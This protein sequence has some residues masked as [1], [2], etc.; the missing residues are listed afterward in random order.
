M[1]FPGLA[2]LLVSG[3]AL[4]QIVIPPSVAPQVSWWLT[5]L[6]PG[7]RARLDAVL[8]A[9]AAVASGVGIAH[10]KWVLER[11]DHATASIA[12]AHTQLK[13]VYESGATP[14]D[15][16]RTE[17]FIGYVPEE[18]E[19]GV[20]VAT[21]ENAE[22]VVRQ[23]LIR[24]WYHPYSPLAPHFESVEE[25]LRR[26][27]V[28]VDPC[29]ATEGELLLSWSWSFALAQAVLNPAYTYMTCPSVDAPPVPMWDYAISRVAN[30]GVERVA[31][32]YVARVPDIVLHRDGDDVYGA[33]GAFEML[34]FLGY[35]AD[36]SVGVDYCSGG[37]SIQ[38]WAM[39]GARYVFDRW[40][41]NKPVGR[42]AAVVN[43][44]AVFRIMGRLPDQGSTST[45]L[46]AGMSPTYEFALWEAISAGN[47]VRDAWAR[48]CMAIAS[49]GE[50][51]PYPWDAEGAP[52]SGTAVRQRDGEAVWWLSRPLEWLKLLFAPSVPLTVRFERLQALISERFPF[53]VAIALRNYVPPVEDGEVDVPCFAVGHGRELCPDPRVL[54]VVAAGSRW[55]AALVLSLGVVLWLQRRLVPSLRL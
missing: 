27:Y 43:R 3:L 33:Y 19:F 24:Y 2:L 28:T 55:G 4:A 13:S 45:F 49:V 51:R 12:E 15:I 21:G 5:E 10:L 23:S 30:G 32:F 20:S 9:A 6:G 44:G 1:R 37:Y 7:F 31:P 11:K 48:A 14:R 52:D 53:S 18:I 50:V 42:L 17:V 41:G 8:R 22:D 54:G 25:A 38:V 35:Y 34:Y 46:Y 36:A 40:E 26:F 47:L 29:P 39:V 16:V